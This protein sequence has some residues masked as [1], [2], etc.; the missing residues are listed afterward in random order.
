VLKLNAKLKFPHCMQCT[1]CSAGKYESQ[2]CSS[3]IDQEKD[4]PSQDRVCSD[5]RE[6][7]SKTFSFLQPQSKYVA[8]M[9]MQLY[10]IK[11]SK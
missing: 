7:S 11:L 1:L 2:S 3:N 6:P 4:W 10:V 5:V 8:N 9:F